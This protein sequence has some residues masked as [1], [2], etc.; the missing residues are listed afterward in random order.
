[1]TNKLEWKTIPNSYI[2]HKK[3]AHPCKSITYEIR[4]EFLTER[5]FGVYLNGDILKSFE[6]EKDAE[7]FGESFH[8]KNVYNLYEKEKQALINN[9]PEASEQEYEKDIRVICERLGV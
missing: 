2:G 8:E 4:G 6:L 1:M 5:W 9:N 3:E 7:L